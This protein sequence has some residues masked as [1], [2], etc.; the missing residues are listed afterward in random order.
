MLRSLILAAAMTLTTT[1]VLAQEAGNAEAV[2]RAYMAAYSQ[3]DWEG[4]AAFM[5]DDIVFADNTATGTDD[6][7]GIETE[8]REALLEM[9]RG[10]EAQYHPIELGFVWDSVFESNGTVV[11]IGHVNALYPTEAEGQVFRWRSQ[12]VAAVTVR[13]GLVVEHR[14]FANYPG[15][16]QGLVPAD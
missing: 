7:D 3:V 14:D 12:Q 8:G 16:E 2:A 4:M 13:G 6:P 11:F 10:F 15:A 5:A 1:P 9:L